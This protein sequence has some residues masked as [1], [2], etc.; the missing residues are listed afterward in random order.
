MA[1]E[2]NFQVAGLAIMMMMIAGL[3]HGTNEWENS[4]RKSTA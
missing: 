3:D 1:G 2:C 4:D